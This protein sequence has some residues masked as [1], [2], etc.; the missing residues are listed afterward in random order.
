MALQR[1]GGNVTQPA[2]YP[3]RARNAHRGAQVIQIDSGK[4][5]AIVGFCAALCAATCVFSVWAV[6]T[7]TRA[8]TEARLVEY[9]LQDPNSRTPEE[10]AAWAKFRKEHAKE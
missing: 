4:H 2:D 10:L 5:I 9:Y 1:K 8:Q 3:V 7:A 6:H